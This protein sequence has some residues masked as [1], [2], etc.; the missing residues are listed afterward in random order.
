MLAGV[1]GGAF[2]TILGNLVLEYFGE[3]SQTQNHA[4]LY[5]AKAVGALVGVGV[6][7]LLIDA[8]GYEQLFV[9]AGV[10]GLVTAVIVRFLKQP[11]RPT[12]VS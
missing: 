10:V 8:V 7:V 11:G 1:G 5:S 3:N 2:Y 9:A 12:L 4:V 6:A